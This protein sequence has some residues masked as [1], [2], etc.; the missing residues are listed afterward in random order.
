MRTPVFRQVLLLAVAFAMA[1]L[2]GCAAR[3]D[4]GSGAVA[5]QSGAGDAS[6]GDAAATQGSQAQSPY[7]I[8]F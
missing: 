4:A 7:S 5:V 2:G 8:P 6:P 1:A 3:G